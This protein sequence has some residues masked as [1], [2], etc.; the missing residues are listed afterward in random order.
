MLSYEP[1]PAD[2]PVYLAV[3]LN[4]NWTAAK[5]VRQ[6]TLKSILRTTHLWNAR[7]P[8]ISQWGVSGTVMQAS[9][10]RVFFPFGVVNRVGFHLKVLL[11][12][13]N[14][15]AKGFHLADG[16]KRWDHWI[17]SCVLD[18]GQEFNFETGSLPLPSSKAAQSSKRQNPLFTS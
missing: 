10:E 6:G 14:N 1:K 5:L 11:T 12:K 9:E 7:S 2:A 17:N 3:C 18:A 13:N 8:Q 15:M 16:L 4:L